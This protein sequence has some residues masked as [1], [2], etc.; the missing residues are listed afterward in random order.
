MKI[1]RSNV[2]FIKRKEFEHETMKKKVKKRCTVGIG[3]LKESGKIL[4]FNEKEIKKGERK[5]ISE[6][7]AKMGRKISIKRKRGD[8]KK[9]N[10]TKEKNKTWK[11]E[12]CLKKKEK[13]TLANEN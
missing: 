1:K 10:K 6:K 5:K 4:H 8:E 2:I 12:N 3:K 9:I 7:E 13:K 11:K